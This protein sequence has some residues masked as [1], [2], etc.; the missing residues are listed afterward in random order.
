M[1]YSSACSIQVHVVFKCVYYS[2]ACTIQVRACSMYLSVSAANWNVNKQLTYLINLCSRMKTEGIY[3]LFYFKSTVF[4]KDAIFS[5]RLEDLVLWRSFECWSERG[6]VCKWFRIGAERVRWWIYTAVWK[7]CNY[8][9][10]HGVWWRQFLPNSSTSPW[11]TDN[12]TMQLD[13]TRRPFLIP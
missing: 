8:L 6:W 13:L 11:I 12:A 3:S 9:F 5:P 2:N 4:F 1:Y 7:T 10:L